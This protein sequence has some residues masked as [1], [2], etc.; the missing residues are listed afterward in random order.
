GWGVRVRTG[1]G[2]GLG[3]MVGTLAVTGPGEAGRAGAA[4][5]GGGGGF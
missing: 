2:T 3:G 5:G 4:G 1:V